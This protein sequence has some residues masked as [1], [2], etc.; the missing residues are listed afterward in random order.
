MPIYRLGDLAPDLDP[1]SWVAPDANVI[2]QVRLARNA[3]V[4]W[5]ATLRGDKDAISIGEES[6]IQD[7]S[8]LHTDFHL[9]LT[10]GRQVPVGHMVMLHGCTIGDRCLIGIGAVILNRA[11][12]G[13]DCLVGA[14]TLVPEDKTFPDRS[15]ILGSPA[16]LVRTLS[17]EE[18]ARL[19]G[20]AERYVRNWQRYRQELIPC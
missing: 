3:S 16:R 8:V 18:V 2:G 11:R 5:N 4:W 6:N 9:H 7:G 17:D 1:E 12:I 14:H 13:N 20:S 15:L 19:P 10:V